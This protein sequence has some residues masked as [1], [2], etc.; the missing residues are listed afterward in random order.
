MRNCFSI[1]DLVGDTD[2]REFGKAVGSRPAVTGIHHDCQ[3]LA[4]NYGGK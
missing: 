2:Y 1:A 4:Y 3:N